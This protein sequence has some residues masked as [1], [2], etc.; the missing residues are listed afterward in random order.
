[1]LTDT[2][3]RKAKGAEKAY[4]L[5]DANGLYLYV[6]PNGYK[7]WRMKYRFAGKEKRL[8]FGPYP[9][10]PLVEARDLRDAARRQLRAG[11]DPA[12]DKRQRSAAQTAR[13]GATFEATAQDWLA[14]MEPTWS[15]RYASIVRRS[16]EQDVFPK[17]GKVPIDAVTTPMVIEVLRPIE[18]RGAIETAHRVRQRISEV[19]AR[20]VGAGAATQDPAALA[21]RALGKVVKGKFPAV[22]T[23]E[24]A[25][26][27]LAKVEAQPAHPLTKLASRLLAL[28][29]VRAGVLR[30]AEPSEFEGLD[31]PAPIWRV[32]AAKMKLVAERK[33]DA[34]FEFIVPL[35]RQ[36]VE[37]VKVAIAFA[38][39]GPLIFRSVRHPRKPIS[40]ST[41]SKAYREAG[42]SG[43]HV[44]HGWRST[45]STILNELAAVESRVGDR[46]IIDLMLAHVP[47]GVEAAYNRAAYMP[48][49]RELAQEWADM[50][51]PGLVEPGELLHGPRNG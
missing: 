17:I 38:G 33:Q 47:S 28:T 10:V 5:A 27:V 35:S 14:S 29:A 21:G 1:V 19:F 51:T 46:A 44:P 40:D 48:R 26:T 12:L 42:F 7:S 20:A 23:V 15:A 22:R 18:R 2:A 11:T 8:T 24:A 49:R 13:A 34:A 30:L 39:K 4:K 25:R 16:M 45:F 9:D 32:P 37:V 31:G 6:T 41:L 36:A 3:C 43:V 50:L